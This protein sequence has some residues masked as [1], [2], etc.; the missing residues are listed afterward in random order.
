MPDHFRGGFV[1]SGDAGG[2]ALQ[3][4]DYRAVGRAIQQ[5][6]GP[7]AEADV[8]DQGGTAFLAAGVDDIQ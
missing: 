6:H 5:G 1:G 4:D 8:G 2:L 3:F 7:V